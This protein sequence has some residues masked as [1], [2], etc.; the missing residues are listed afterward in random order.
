[1]KNYTLRLNLAINKINIAYLASI[2]NESISE[3]ELCFMYALDDDKSHSQKEICHDWLIHKTT[4][5]TIVKRY[6]RKGLIVFTP[7]PGTRREMLI[8]LTEKGKEYV[9]EKL[10]FI[11]RAEKKAIKKTIEQYDEN[12]ISALETYGLNLKLAFEEAE[13]KKNGLIKR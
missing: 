6:E 8:T 2:N 12:F 4:L 9:K 3:A 10:D 13:K 11:Y 1:M 5:N 7:I